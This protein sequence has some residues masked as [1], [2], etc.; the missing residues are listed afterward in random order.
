[1]DPETGCRY[2]F[3]LPLSS[4]R[5]SMYQATIWV[6]STGVGNEVSESSHSH[7]VGEGRAGGYSRRIL[8]H[9]DVDML[10]LHILHCAHLRIIPSFSCVGENTDERPRLKEL[11]AADAF[12]AL[13]LHIRDCAKL[14]SFP[15]LDACTQLLRIEAAHRRNPVTKLVALTTLVHTKSN[16]SLWC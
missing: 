11:P 4:E 10:Q 1:M 15:S 16:E 2:D 13:R 6:G 9:W 3:Q 14:G 7:A 12:K 5:P 8:P